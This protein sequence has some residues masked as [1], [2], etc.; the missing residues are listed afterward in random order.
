MNQVSLTMNKYINMKVNELPEWLKRIAEIRCDEQ[1][2]S[3]NWSENK[4]V[5]SLF[6]FAITPEGKD[7]WNNVVDN[8]DFGRSNYVKVGDWIKIT[9]SDKYWCP[10][11][12]DRFIGK[13]V[14]VTDVILNGTCHIICKGHSSL[15]WSVYSGHFV[16]THPPINIMVEE[17]RNEF[18][19]G[20][21]VRLSDW[22]KKT[23]Q[24]GANNPY[25]LVGTIKTFT[26]EYNLNVQVKWAENI[27]NSY[28]KKHLIK[29]IEPSNFKIGDKVRI[30]ELGLK[31]RPYVISNWFGTITNI[32]KSEN[33]S[34]RIEW[35]N[36]ECSWCEPE[37]IELIHDYFESSDLKQPFTTLTINIQTEE[38]PQ[39]NNNGIILSSTTRTVSNTTRINSSSVSCPTIKICI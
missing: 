27:T 21:K 33:L 7:F 17:T 19:V 35:H 3:S 22:G 5:N 24:N 38:T 36:E 16:K 15:H 9:K 2:F 11:S 20:D 37:W 1:G 29:I 4:L 18:K 30:N 39:I 10:I 28:S 31:R 32:D 25:N 23:Y 8:K 13:V 6:N 12:M 26:K 14:Q 34:I